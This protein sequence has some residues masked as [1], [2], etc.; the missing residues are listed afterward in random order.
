MTTTI[1]VRKAARS[2]TDLSWDAETILIAQLAA[3]IS[4]LSFFYYLRQG[5]VLLYGDV[6]GHINIARRVF[7]SRTPGPLQLGTVWLPLPHLLMIPF[8]ISQ[9][10]WKTG[11]GGSIPSLVA[12]V[13]AV[14]GI[15]RLLRG[16]LSPEAQPNVA[17][18]RA[19]WIA[20][21]IFAANP[22]LIYM[23][24]TA[25]NE[26]LYLAF[27]IWAVVYFSEFV[28]YRNN[29][30]Q[31]SNAAALLTKSGLCIF[32]ACMTRYDGWFVATVMACIALQM[33]IRSKLKS[34]AIRTALWKFVLLAVAAPALWLTYN[35]I[36]YGNPL[37]FADGP[38]SARGLARNDAVAGTAPYPGSH[39]L[40]IAAAFYVK[41]AEMNLAA[42][43]WG[44]LWLAAAVAGVILFAKR[45]REWW[46]LSLLAL[47]L[48]FYMLSIAYGGVAMYLPVWWPHTYYN[49]RYGL[50]LLPAIA[51]IVGLVAYQIGIGVEQSRTRTAALSTLVLAVALSYILVWRA[52]PICLQEAIVNS[53]TRI[54]LEGAL[55]DNLKKLPA[56][57]TILMYL[58][59]HVGALQRAGIS[60]RRTINEGNS[61]AWRKPANEPGLWDA[62]LANPSGFA[63]YVV[64]ADGDAVAKRVNREGLKSLL[65]IHVPGEAPVRI[66]STPRAVK[67]Q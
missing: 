44:R 26:A 54:P 31:A 29:Q 24:A 32:A 23:Q 48:P 30:A 10:M 65:V 13:M 39:D 34:K 47:P 38:Y 17:A 7:D 43:N 52:Q 45:R 55:G 3:C 8:L 9:W 58:G 46:P 19:A 4:L 59:D 16:S 12:F 37:E 1:A 20:A 49:V 22:N 21:A 56:D 61:W 60:L 28:R 14:A 36:I 27:F 62:A 18:R 35:A 51:V 25:M 63:D 64:A 40:S 15:F 11:V 67:T 5:D 50:G 6:F 33:L 41:A 66:Y 53:R 57:A 42:G 2:L